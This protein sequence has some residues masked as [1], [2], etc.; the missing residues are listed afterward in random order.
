MLQYENLTSTDTMGGE[1]AGLKS[2]LG[3]DP[4]LPSNELPLTNYKHMGWGNS[5]DAVSGGE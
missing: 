1:L 3:L 2:F 4:E 5:P